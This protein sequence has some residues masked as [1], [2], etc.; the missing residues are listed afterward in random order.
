MRC[1]ILELEGCFNVRD[2]GG[3]PADSGK[4][5]RHRRFIRAGTLFGMTERGKAALHDLGIQCVIDLRSQRE[6]DEH[7][8]A[9][10]HDRRF[11]WFHLPMLDYVHSGITE[12]LP[13]DFPSSLEEM[14][15]GLLEDSKAKF[16]KLFTLF[17]SPAYESYLF[18]CTAGKD[19]TGV[20]AMLLLALAGVDEQTIVEDY[21]HSEKLIQGLFDRAILADLPA[22]LFLSRAQTMRAALQHL[23]SQYGSGRAYLSQIGITSELQQAILAKLTG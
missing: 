15:I 13:E 7:P 22:H 19:R 2:L 3:Y 1:E 6:V 11:A 4:T 20:V 8:D 12:V 21:S 23:K 18:H 10:M 14:Y 5:T 17:A 16:E 9:V